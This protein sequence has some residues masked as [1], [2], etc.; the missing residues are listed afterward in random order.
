MTSW[1]GVFD[2]EKI[3]VETTFVAPMWYE[4]DHNFSYSIQ[5]DR[6]E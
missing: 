5:H 1:C 2:V 6:K 3:T 4:E